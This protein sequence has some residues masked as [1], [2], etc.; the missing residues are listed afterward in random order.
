MAAK[1]V[2]SFLRITACEVLFILLIFSMNAFASQSVV[3]IDP[4]AEINGDGSSG[5]PA[6][7]TGSPG[8][9]NTWRGIS[10]NPNT[11]YYQKCQTEFVIDYTFDISAVGTASNP[12]VFGAYY[13]DGDREIIGVQGQKPIIRRNPSTGYALYIWGSKYLGFKDMDIRGGYCSVTLQ[14]ASH[15]SFDNCTIGN[16][17]TTYGL[18]ITG[19][20]IDE[21]YVESN[22]GE[23]MNCVLDPNGGNAGDGIKLTNGASYW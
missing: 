11:A 8:A 7:G 23:I 21:S 17:A 22:Y 3:Y 6:T 19:K 16:Y 15:I 5:L 2:F 10:I 9:Y 13:L 4:S 14:G 18:L 20:I 1:N 12:I